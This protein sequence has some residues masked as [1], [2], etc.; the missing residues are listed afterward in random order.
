MVLPRKY[1]K[2]PTAK[3]TAKKYKKSP[4]A[5]K[6]IFKK[7]SVSIFDKAKP[8]IEG[9]AAGGT[10]SMYRMANSR[11][12]TVPKFLKATQELSNQVAE[13][14]SYISNV[15]KQ[16]AFLVN[17]Q[18]GSDDVRQ[19]ASQIQTYILNGSTPEVVPSIDNMKYYIDHT[20]GTYTFRNNTNNEMILDI[21]DLEPRQSGGLLDPVAIWQSGM[22]AGGANV[23]DSQFPGS[24]P[25]Q[26][27]FFTSTFIVKKV[28]NCILPLG[29]MHEHKVHYAP[30][31]IFN[32]ADLQ[33]ASQFK[34][35]TQFVMV[36]FRGAPC[37]DATDP[38]IPTISPTQLLCTTQFVTY[39]RYIAA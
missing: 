10:I 7:K 30:R 14:F 16:G 37:C 21:Y 5:K 12:R 3:K 9:H 33:N 28:T 13:A 2:S 38:N 31:R 29:S 4:T 27:A 23:F 15:G 11:V 32:M 26:S 20:T 17:T 25:F 18:Y 6:L 24:S 39:L 1:K 34:G 35:L 19:F 8:R 36:V 22:V